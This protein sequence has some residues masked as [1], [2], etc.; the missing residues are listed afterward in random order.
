MYRLDTY[1]HLFFLIFKQIECET[2]DIAPQTLI[3]DER[4][5]HRKIHAIIHCN[6]FFY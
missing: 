2:L 1:R 4:K 3:S 5:A 6:E